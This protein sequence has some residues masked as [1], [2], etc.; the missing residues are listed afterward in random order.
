M[1]SSE[2][3]GEVVR[4]SLVD[5][6]WPAF[7]RTHHIEA[8]G[9]TE[10]PSHRRS[11][12][13]V[14]AAATQ[15]AQATALAAFNLTPRRTVAFLV[16]GK[17]ADAAVVEC[18]KRLGALADLDL[19]TPP[20]SAAKFLTR[21]LAADPEGINDREWGVVLTVCAALASAG[22]LDLTLAAVDRLCESRDRGDVDDGDDGDGS[23][24][25]T[26]D[27]GTAFG[28]GAL[29]VVASH[30]AHRLLGSTDDGSR[31]AAAFDPRLARQLVVLVIRSRGLAQVLAEAA[32]AALV[33]D[34]NRSTVVDAALEAAL[35][36]RAPEHARVVGEAIEAA[37]CLQTL[38]GVHRLAWE[39]WIDPM[40]AP[41][42]RFRVAD[43]DD[44]AAVEVLTGLSEAIVAAFE[45]VCAFSAWWA[46]LAS[47]GGGGRGGQV[48]GCVSVCL[49][50]WEKVRTHLSG[51]AG[52]ILSLCM[53]VYLI[54]PASVP[55]RDWLP[56]RLAGADPIR[57]RGRP[58]V[59]WAQ[60]PPQPSPKPSRPGA[61]CLSLSQA[62]PKHNLGLWGRS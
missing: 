5:L 33:Q 24:N 58:V 37:A 23:D 18:G 13:A 3:N 54:S 41:V 7:A 29:T 17:H 1:A 21:L 6:L 2:S 34:P 35:A 61:V 39:A 26:L 52:G 31:A 38:F 55:P 40:V 42:R 30:L 36:E 62:R 47:K 51:C 12:E 60:H 49:S 57:G 20:A 14:V 27:L 48:C 46:L 32:V 15:A 59:L 56:G 8:D 28:R 53:Y 22:L 45:E 4:A 11:L 50:A 10:P 16:H 25:R 43:A 44:G 9:G 19:V